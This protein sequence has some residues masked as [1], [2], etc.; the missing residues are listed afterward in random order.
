MANG[1][2]LRANSLACSKA[3]SSARLQTPTGIR[4][5]LPYLL[6]PEAA[7]SILSSGSYEINAPIWQPVGMGIGR[8]TLDSLDELRL[9]VD[10]VQNFLPIFD[11]GVRNFMVRAI[12]L[13]NHET[14]DHPS[15]LFLFI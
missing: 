11:F 7:T 2:C 14:L 12:A 10:R 9:S 6:D 3:N 1:Y 5:T 15:I 4:S 13:M 8:P